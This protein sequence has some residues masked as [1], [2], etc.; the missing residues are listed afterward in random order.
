M[1]SLE[2]PQSPKVSSPSRVAVRGTLQLMMAQAC[3]MICGYIVVITLARGLGPKEYGIYGIII[4]VLVGVELISSLGIPQALGKLIAEDGERSSQFERTGLALSLIVFLSIFALFW[5]FAPAM[6]DLFQIKDG[7]ALFRLAAIDIPFYG[8]YFVCIR[9]LGGRRQFG[10]AGLGES[11]YG[12]TKASGIMIL[13]F[14]GLSVQGALIIN[15]I[16]SIGAL[17]YMATRVSLRDIYPVLGLIK[18]ILRLALPLGLFTSGLQV[19]FNLDL[20][21]L[22]V[23]GQDL[24]EETIGIYI[25]AVNVAK[26]PLVVSFVMTAV[27]IPSLTRAEALNDKALAQRYIQGAVRSLWV[28][29]LPVCFL[30]ALTAEDLMALLYSNQYKEGALFLRIL[31]FGFGLSFTFLITFGAM[32]IGK[33][34]PFFPARITLS[35]IPFALL[36]NIV[37]ISL[38]GAMGAA[39]S[40]ILTGTGGATVL[41]I[42]VHRHTGL[43]IT[44]S[45]LIK[46]VIAAVLMILIAPQFSLRGP[47]LLLEYGVLFGVYAG[48]LAFLGELKWKD[49]QPVMLW[50]RDQV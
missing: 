26:L 47:M 49:L 46:V 42:L 29:L 11:L 22:K 28:V 23:L 50:R 39:V 1:S 32:L 12:L 5:L 44:R 16:A 7:T 8:L 17:L 18:P 10:I 21:C 41:G 38:Y 34:L 40:V 20:W 15:I 6:A 36:L 19:L 43:L 4:S 37:L 31:I 2:L 14:L 33:G 25:A 13:F 3:L 48:A 24:A 35:L 27:L 9:I 45:A 30:F